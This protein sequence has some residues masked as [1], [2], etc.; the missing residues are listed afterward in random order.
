MLF[1]AACEHSGIK[2]GFRKKIE[3]D[4]PAMADLHGQGGSTGKKKGASQS[5]DSNLASS[6]CWGCGKMLVINSV[7]KPKPPVI[8]GFRIQFFSFGYYFFQFFFRDGFKQPVHS[9]AVA[10]GQDPLNN[11]S[12]VQEQIQAAKVAVPK[13]GFQYIGKH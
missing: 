8:S 11:E 10:V 5:A 13:A 3:I 12:S 1:K 9:G 4:G 6:H 7:L 2:F